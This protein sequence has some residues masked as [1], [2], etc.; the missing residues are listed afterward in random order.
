MGLSETTSVKGDMGKKRKSLT[1][2]VGRVTAGGKIHVYTFIWGDVADRE[3]A[4][5]QSLSRP[6]SQCTRRR[7]NQVDSGTEMLLLV[8]RPKW[9][10]PRFQNTSRDSSQQKSGDRSGRW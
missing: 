8:S 6:V 7:A 1:K 4:K 3:H 10:Q 5:R 9:L 2:D